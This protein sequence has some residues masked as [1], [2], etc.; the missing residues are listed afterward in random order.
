MEAAYPD[1]NRGK[2]LALTPLREQLVGTIRS[3]L[4]F[5]MGAV[6][7]V[8]L[9]ACANVA[10]L[11]LARATS[12]SREMAVRAALGAGPWRIIRQL[13]VESAALSILGGALGLLLAQTA[14]HLLLRLAPENLP[15]LSEIRVDHWALAF[16]AAASL[17][18]SFLFGLAPAW[19]ASRVDLNEALKQ[20][21]SRGMLGGGSHHL[22]HALLVAEISLCSVLAIG[23]GLLVRSFLNLSAVELGFRTERI[24]VMYAHAP[25][26]GLQE[27]LRSARFFQNLFPQLAVIPDV[28]SVAAAM[29][30]PTGQYGSNGAYAVEGKH[31]FAPGQ[32]LPQAG[33]RLASPG[34]F[35]T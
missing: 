25:A 20:G 31:T 6:S 5:L 11:L 30:L 19:Q 3:T 35:S 23:A 14:T 27:H 26:R 22:R 24:L 32:K 17:L 29:G 2:E 18:A 33:F 28:K 9:I 16:T 8:L 15:R 10:N 21:A 7:L 4:W 34:Y 13:V 1:S 12:R